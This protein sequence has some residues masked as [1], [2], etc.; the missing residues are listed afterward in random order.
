M[1]PYVAANAGIGGKRITQQIRREFAE[2]GQAGVLPVERHIF[3]T[4]ACNHVP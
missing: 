1:M 3:N 4:T 2:P